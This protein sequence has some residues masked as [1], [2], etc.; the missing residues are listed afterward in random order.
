M[1]PNQVLCA[2]C[3]LD[4]FGVPALSGLMAATAATRVG[5][6]RPCTPLATT[7]LQGDGRSHRTQPPDAQ[8]GHLTPGSSRDQRPDLNPVLGEVVVEH[9]ASIPVRMQ[10]LRGQS[11][12]GTAFGPVVRDHM[13][14]LPPLPPFW[15]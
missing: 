10:P 15:G 13:A 2:E 4:D 5:L 9:Q 6:T 8:V 1:P 11:H 12:D 14:P 3:R 7:R